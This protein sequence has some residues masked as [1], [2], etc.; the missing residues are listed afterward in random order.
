MASAA[1]RAACLGQVNDVLSEARCVM[2]FDRNA[3]L[4]VYAEAIGE[5]SKPWAWAIYRGT[6]RFLIT[7][8]RPAYRERADALEAGFKAA[9]D[10]SRRLR[11]DVAAGD[12]DCTQGQYIT[13]A[14]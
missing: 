2:S 6:G 9:R 3:T 1:A 10:V 12:A 5:A 7:R 4:R 13:S 14:P 11:V 8:S